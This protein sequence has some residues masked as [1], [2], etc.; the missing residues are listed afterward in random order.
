MPGEEGSAEV[1]LRRGDWMQ[2]G[3]QRDLFRTHEG[4]RW[5]ESPPVKYVPTIIF[6][7]FA[8]FVPVFW[9]W[10]IAKMLGKRQSIPGRKRR[11]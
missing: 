9:A 4:E 7:L 5:K 11:R 6:I 1:P 2:G 3:D 10:G 8:P